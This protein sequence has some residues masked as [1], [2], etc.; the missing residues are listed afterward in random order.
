MI[1]YAN[2][3]I[4]DALE[5]LRADVARRFEQPEFHGPAMAALIDLLDN[6][7]AARRRGDVAAAA[8]LARSA[9]P[10]FET[11]RPTNATSRAK[12]ILGELIADLVTEPA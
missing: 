2:E 8:V 1:A 12:A 7:E 4:D 3:D 10:A 11:Y 9:Q 6:M 5:R